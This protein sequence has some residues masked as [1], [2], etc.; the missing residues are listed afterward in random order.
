MRRFYFN[1][2]LFRLAACAGLVVGLCPRVARAELI[3]VRA[4]GF[5]LGQSAQCAGTNVSQLS[6]V[7]ADL[8]PPFAQSAVKQDPVPAGLGPDPAV[9]YFTVRFALPIPPENATNLVASLVG[10]D[11][12]IFTHNHSPGFELLPNGDALAIYFSTPP[13]KAEND[14]ATSF[15][16]ARLRYGTVEWSLPELF[17]KTLDHNDQSGLLWNDAGTLRFFGGGRDLSDWTPFKTAVSADNGMTWTL[18]FPQLDAAADNYTAQP[19]TSAFRGGDG[20]MYFAMDGS[21]SHS[22]LW[23]SQDGGTHWHDMGGRT[24]ARHSAIVPLDNHGDLLSIGGKNAEVDGWSP[25][26]RSTNWGASWSSSVASPFPP[27]GSA[28]RPSLIKLANGHLFF[29]SDAF[30]QKKK[31][32]PPAGWKFGSEVFVAVS[33]DLGATWHIKSLPVQLPNHEYRTHGTVGYVT[34][35]QAPNGVIHILTTETQ[36]CLHYELNE[37]WVFSDVGDLPPEATGGTLRDFAENYPDGKP[38]A[39]WTARICP[40]GRYLLEGHAVDYYE[41]G[42]VA[43]EATYLA[44]RRTGAETFR[45]P[46]GQVIWTWEQDL[47]KGS[48]VWTRY[49]PNGR[50]QSQ[51]NWDIQPQ[52]RDLDRAFFGAVANGPA[53][54]WTPEGNPLSYAIFS[55]GRLSW[56]PD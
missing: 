25:E 44:G 38:R 18:S 27:L 52:A 37:A 33:A 31:Q 51:S 13:G 39:R 47:A 10:L 43:H 4:T 42:V 48:A 8:A 34:A 6:L 21:G 20:A 54:R 29:V 56:L 11:A 35:R 19:I 5:A 14:P 28:Q 17:F 53:Q 55:H 12:Q 23:R 22:F 26:N 9:P 3:T 16:Q 32:A 49:W 45:A 30:L 15:I 7:P 36:P 1:S 40:H 24:G 2:N 50:K 41:N 46:N